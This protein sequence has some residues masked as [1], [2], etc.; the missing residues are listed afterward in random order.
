MVGK[1][2]AI[3]SFIIS[4]RHKMVLGSLN[5]IVVACGKNERNEKSI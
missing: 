2:I 4:F 1:S 3:R 5:E